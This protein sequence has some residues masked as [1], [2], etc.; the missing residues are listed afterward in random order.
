MSAEV[1][2]NTRQQL[3]GALRKKPHMQSSLSPGRLLMRIALKW[4]GIARKA[5]ETKSGEMNSEGRLHTEVNR[6]RENTAGDAL[7]KQ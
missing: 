4:N 1:P 6:M 5:F 7:L 2:H 3:Q